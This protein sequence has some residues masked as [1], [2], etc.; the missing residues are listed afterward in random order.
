MA[1]TLAG[2]GRQDLFVLFSKELDLSATLPVL[3]NGLA[4]SLSGTPATVDGLSLVRGNPRAL[5]FHLTSPVT[6]EDL[7]NA[8]SLL[9]VLTTG[10]T[11][12]DP[13][14]NTWLPAS[15]FV[16]TDGNYATVG[17]THELTNIGIGLVNIL[18]GADNVNK[19]GLLSA[20]E[21]ALRATGSTAR[22]GSSTAT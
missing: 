12:L 15:Y 18:Y 22:D 9:T 6:A 19:A 4:V 8:S 21:G 20:T 13:D 1:F 2:A 17:A 5:L 7:V 14:T 16:D 11:Y 3:Q 10:G